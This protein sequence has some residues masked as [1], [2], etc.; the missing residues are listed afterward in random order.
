[1]AAPFL[2][3]T[4]YIA[5]R[6][7]HEGNI[8]LANILLKWVTRVAFKRLQID[9]KQFAVIYNLEEFGT[10]LANVL[11]DWAE[12]IRKEAEQ[13]TEIRVRDRI[14]KE[15]EQQTEIRVRELEN[16]LREAERSRQEAERSRQEAEIRVRELEKNLR[17]VKR[18]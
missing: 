10:M 13:Q 17:E 3:P 12:R 1:M 11:P 18:T 6:F 9:E 15:V 7:R 16:K 4:P 14:R 5:I 2:K 8:D